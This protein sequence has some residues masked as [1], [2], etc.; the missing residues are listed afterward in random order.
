MAFKENIT[1]K[2]ASIK[3]NLL[4]SKKFDQLINKKNIVKCKQQLKKII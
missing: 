2:E 1:L 4:S 3:L